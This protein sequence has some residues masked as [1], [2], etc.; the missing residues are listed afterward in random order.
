[1]NQPTIISYSRV[2]SDRQ[3]SGTGL[4]LQKG[5]RV[6]EEL[7]HKY[8]LPIDTRSQQDHEN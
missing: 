1:M 8:A 6:L 2:S 4:A 3:I 7:S 5:T